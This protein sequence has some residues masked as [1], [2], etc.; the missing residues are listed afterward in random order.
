VLVLRRP[1][2]VLSA[3][4]VAVTLLSGCVDDFEGAAEPTQ[5]LPPAVSELAKTDVGQFFITPRQDV[6]KATVETT[7]GKLK[8]M[9][10]VQKAALEQDGR[11]NL[12]FRPGASD[13]ERDAALKQAGALGTIDEG[14]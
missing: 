7:L 13:A 3:A 14:I 6:D 1:A 10:G 12:E 2:L 5:T 9:A 8:T 11:I 4:A